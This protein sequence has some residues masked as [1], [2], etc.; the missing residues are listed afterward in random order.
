[1]LFGANGWFYD[2]CIEDDIVIMNNNTGIYGIYLNGQLVYIGKT[3]QSFYKRYLQHKR[4]ITNPEDSETQYNMY[5]ELAEELAKGSSVELKPIF[6]A[7]TA[8]YNSLYHLTNRDLESMEFILIHLL[9]PRY[10]ILG[11]KKP[12]RY[13]H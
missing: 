1:M 3:T 6:E 5:Y 12:Y 7:E 13:T 9:R 10:N 11:V 4:L 2:N 8:A